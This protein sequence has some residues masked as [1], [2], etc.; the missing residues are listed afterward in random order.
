MTLILLTRRGILFDCL[1]DGDMRECEIIHLSLSVW[2]LAVS[3]RSYG[4]AY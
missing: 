3:E 1:T 4:G 2:L